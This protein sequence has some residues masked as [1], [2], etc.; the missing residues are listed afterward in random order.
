LTE[1]GMR[2]KK[3][4]FGRIVGLRRM[5]D[6]PSDNAMSSSLVSASPVDR[7]G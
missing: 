4:A 1:D 7:R 6:A 5:A 2:S 3:S